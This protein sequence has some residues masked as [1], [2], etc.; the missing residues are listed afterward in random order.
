MNVYLLCI[1]KVKLTWAAVQGGFDFSVIEDTSEGHFLFWGRKEDKAQ[2][3][4]SITNPKQQSYYNIANILI[5]DILYLG[6]SPSLR[7]WGTVTSE[8]I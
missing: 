2:G 4:I 1:K 7:L 6:D 3:G 5:A 8:R